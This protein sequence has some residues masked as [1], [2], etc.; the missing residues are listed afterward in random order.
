M[1]TKIIALIE[2]KYD[3]PLIT[4][5][6]FKMDLSKSE[7]MIDPATVGAIISV[8]KFLYET[9]SKSKNNNNDNIGN[10][11]LT[12][13]HKLNELLR[14]FEDIKEELRHIEILIDKIPLKD[15]ENRLNASINVYYK[16][17]FDLRQHLNDKA[18]YEIFLNIYNNIQYDEHTTQ[19][20]SFCHLYKLVLAF[21]IEF[22]IACA[23]NLNKKT[24]L[25]IIYQLKYYLEKAKNNNEV[26][27]YGQILQ[28]HKNTLTKLTEDYQPFNGQE[29]KEYFSRVTTQY[30]RG[31]RRS[32]NEGGGGDNLSFTNSTISKIGYNYCITGNLENGF[33]L[34]STYIGEIAQPVIILDNQ[35]AL[36]TNLEETKNSIK[37]SIQSKFSEYQSKSI[38]YLEINKSIKYFEDIITDINNY[39]NLLEELI[40]DL[41]CLNSEELNLGII[42][43]SN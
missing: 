20:S 11:I 33:A 38:L 3:K 1:K 42:E 12:I 18:N 17:V 6:F 7:L 40:S 23:F 36:S 31:P 27:S 39:V 30:D 5:L 14:E 19:E 32:K 4:D 22:E 34:E 16:N 41:D 26:G 28:V 10:W 21:I 15:A 2:N 37:N 43:H 13:D 35:R 9:L 25:A 29:I 24:K 8:G